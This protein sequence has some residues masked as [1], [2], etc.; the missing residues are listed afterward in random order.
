MGTRI[1]LA[2]DSIT[3]QKVVNL[4]FA[5]EGI[6]VVSV[7]NGDMAE[8]RLNEVNPDLVLAD[9]FMPGKNGYE[10]CE[11]IKQSPQFGNVP[12]VLLVGAFEPFDQ[13]EARRVRADAHLT[14]PFESRTLVETVRRLISSSRGVRTGS[15]SPV[16]PAAQPG[17]RQPAGGEPGQ[18]VQPTQRPGFSSATTEAMPA[19]PPAAGAP[20]Q[21]PAQA[22]NQGEPPAQGQRV[23]EDFQPLEI[24]LAPAPY[25]EQPD[26]SSALPWMEQT[27]PLADAG[28][29]QALPADP[30]DLAPLEVSAH[31]AVDGPPMVDVAQGDTPDLVLG[32]ENVD[33]ELGDREPEFPSGFAADDDEMILDLGGPGPVHAQESDSSAHVDSDSGGAFNFNP[34][35]SHGRT[36]QPHSWDDSDVFKTQMLE[37]PA[38]LSHVEERINTNPLEMPFPSDF[39]RPGVAPASFAEAH[40]EASSSTLLAVD[41]PLGD[42][43]LDERGA[44]AVSYE[45][46]TDPEIRF[47]EQQSSEEFALEFNPQEQQ[48][49]DIG[50][51][52]GAARMDQARAETD[53]YISTD[54]Y[55]SEESPAAIETIEQMAEPHAPRVEIMADNRP[56]LSDDAASAAPDIGPSGGAQAGPRE[57]DAG[58]DWSKSGFEFSSEFQP[59]ASERR[60]DKVEHT[61]GGPEARAD[62]G[63]A[64]LSGAEFTTSSMWNEQDARFAPIDI[65]A[66]AVDEFEPAAG[67]AGSGA[68]ETGFEIAP[69]VEEEAAHFTDAPS[70]EAQGGAQSSAPEAAAQAADLSPALVDEIVRRVISQMTESVVREI[71][72]EVVPDV[73]E[74]VIKEM[75]RGEISKRN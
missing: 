37:P 51:Q 64:R 38:G 74:R 5:D 33:L 75:A 20:D 40:E 2:D 61:F 22:A 55:A 12:V 14:K 44:G 60:P 70:A 54:D 34:G 57:R 13:A 63:R 58:A 48:V 4:T 10:L 69:A 52:A 6:E 7:S 42:V 71:A 17:E 24:D 27:E 35:R 29:A 1:L 21:M 49:F 59:A 50:G 65:E 73:V 3:I 46:G 18:A 8:R 16:A 68:V 32:D 23:E 43:L 19:Q 66:T 56:Q 45:S 9:I 72:W 53:D 25:Q 39:N 36:S 11:S 28:A 67:R 15:L 62:E 41:E 31:E 30:F 26:L 47:A